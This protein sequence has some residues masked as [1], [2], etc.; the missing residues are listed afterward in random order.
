MLSSKLRLLPQVICSLP[1]LNIIFFGQNSEQ[2]MS[3][4]GKILCIK[5]VTY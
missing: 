3:E 4:F 5:L 1:N 2:K